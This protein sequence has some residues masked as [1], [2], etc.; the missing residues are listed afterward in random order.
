MDLSDLRQNYK[1]GQLSI[2]DSSASPFEQ[3]EHWF[4][5]AQELPD[6]NAMT[7]ATVDKDGQPYARI[8][9]LKGL[10]DG[11]FRF[12]T[13]YTSD[14]GQ[15]IQGNPN[16]ALN[17]FWQPLQRQVQV[18]GRIH[19]LGRE[20]SAAYF[21]KRPRE[22]Q[23]GA[24]VSERQSEEIASRAVLEERKFQIEK[25][26]DGVSEIPCPEHWGGYALVPTEIEFWQGRP[27]RLHDRILYKVQKDNSW[28]K[29]LL[30]P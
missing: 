20:D 14:K 12:F 25:Q 17:F 8:L 7:L 15:Q 19:K 30:S 5:E 10:E 2:S 24:L 1:K 4:K 28:V 27:G 21:A 13:N 16:A 9:L 3:F 18:R 22:S 29:V 23:I 6:A 26:F 11:E